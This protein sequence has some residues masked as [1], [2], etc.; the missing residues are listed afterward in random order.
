M[1]FKTRAKDICR[2]IAFVGPAVVAVALIAGCRSSEIQGEP[3]LN[4]L[5]ITIDTL[6]ADALGS[7]GNTKVSTPWL[8]RVAAGGVRFSRALAQT[9]VTLPSHANILSGRYPFRHGV[10]ENSGFR[11]PDDLDTLATLLKARGYRTGAF[12]SAF[13]L[14]VRFGLGRGFDVYDDRY[15]KGTERQAFREPERPG[16]ATVGA[17]VSW[18]NQQS[19][20]QSTIRNPQ[21]AS[22]WFA[23]VHLYEPHFPY[24][25]PEPFAA[26]YRDQPYL[27]EVSA[28]DAALAPLLTPI[29]ELGAAGRTIVVI[30]GDHGESLG[31]HGELTHGLFAYDATL[32]VPLIVYQPR[33]FP[34]RIVADPVRHVDILPTVLD[35]V[36]IAPPAGLDGVSLFSALETGR[37]VAAPSYFEALSASLNRGWAPLVGVVSGSLKYIDLPIPE[38][39]DEASDPAESRNLAASRPEQVRQMVALLG[40]LRAN[41]RGITR[42]PENAETRERLRSLGYLAASATPKTSYTEADDPKGLV[43]LDRETDE[44][45]TRYQRGDLRG[46]IA[47]GESLVR[48]RPDM[49]VSLTHLAFLY[50]E[51]GDH[52][53]AARMARRALELNP[54][55]ADVASLLG[56]YLTEAGQAKEA[57]TR[58]EAYAGAPQPDVDVLVAYGVALASS[59]RSGEALAAF[60][61]ARAI[62][63]TNGLPLA[64]IGMAHLMAGDRDRASAAFTG[65]LTIDPALA[66]AH[67]G[68]GVIAAQRGALEEA[69]MHWKRAVAFDPHDHQVLYNL[70]DALIRLGRSAEARSYWE[71]Y[72]REAPQGLDE[73]DR[74]RVRAWLGR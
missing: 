17:A 65:A 56:A 25:P 5:L 60:E 73:Q 28:A 62:D 15:G 32:R 9:V 72:L 47:L 18:I 74:R 69:T 45:I 1:P 54:A 53:S 38:L 31:D 52:A 58:L 27:G 10:R 6:R 61:R 68:L 7:Y 36:G 24:A 21:S 42:I 44:L 67:N 41:D 26:R 46:A 71:M 12:V 66:R 16:T 19:N 35:A 59:G 55:A 43:G 3:G 70:G 29:V 22:P 20:P 11:F 50:N 64:N 51:A 14:D 13:P 39:Y 49:A 4:V 37:H 40:Q 2:I 8:D 57:V 23:W 48:R 34:P 30:T 63:P 33:L